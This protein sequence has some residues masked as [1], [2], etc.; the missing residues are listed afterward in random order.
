MADLEKPAMGQ[1]AILGQVVRC[2]EQFMLRL[3]VGFDEQSAL[4]Q[5]PGLPNHPIWTLGHCAFT[6]TRVAASFDGTDLPAD[7]FTESD[8]DQGERV[9]FEIRS[10]CRGSLPTSDSHMYPCLMRSQSIFASACQRLANTVS[11][12]KDDELEAELQWHDG[13]I[14]VVNLIARVC[15]HNGAHSGQI[16]DLR[17]VLDMPRVIG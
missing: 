7:D 2:S 1:A 15:F 5:R 3:M 13:P 8:S 12:L 11:H 6:M 17:R 10:I 4:E 9:R 16:L 14:S